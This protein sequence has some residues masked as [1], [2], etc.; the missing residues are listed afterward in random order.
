M[1]LPMHV[2][3]RRTM[4]LTAAA[5]LAV[6]CAGAGPTVAPNSASASPSAIGS[7]TTSAGCA[8][9][10]V[11]T[12]LGLPPWAESGGGGNIPWAVGR[13]PEVV[14]VLFATELVAK[15]ERPDGSTNKILWLTRGPVASSQLTLRARPANAAT[16]IVTLRFAG[17]QQFPSIVDLPTPG[18]WQIDISWSAG[19]TLNS[20]FGLTVL[21]AGSLPAR[22]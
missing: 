7:H 14:G 17:Y 11:S 13:P 21:P 6:S 2:G 16:P 19:P 5:L 18:C 1:V 22:S 15:G 9:T 4:V 12:G 10:E 3:V 20:T 8:G